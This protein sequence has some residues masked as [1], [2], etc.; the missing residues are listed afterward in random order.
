MSFVPLEANPE[1][2]NPYAAELGLDLSKFRFVDVLG[3]DDELLGLIPQPIEAAI[4]L[5]PTPDDL[6]IS[7]RASV[8]Q[9]ES[10]KLDDLVYFRQKVPN[11]C[12]TIV[13]SILARAP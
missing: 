2:F 9:D 11:Q 7:R 10:L 1:S 3:L 8:S 12:G 6:E 5:Y 13:R 4:L